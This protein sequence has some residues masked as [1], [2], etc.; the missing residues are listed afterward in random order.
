MAT[1]SLYKNFNVITSAFEDVSMKLYDV[2][3]TFGADEYIAI[4]D[5]FSDHRSLPDH[6]REALY[7]GVKEVIIKHDGHHN[8]GY[9]FQLYMGRKL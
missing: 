1:R 3:R 4:L 8:V 2:L 5:T 9:V 6:E 7:A